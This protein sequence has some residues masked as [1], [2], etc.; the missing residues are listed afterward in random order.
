[1]AI[2]E[3]HTVK[4]ELTPEEILAITTTFT[5][6]RDTTIALGIEV[7]KELRHQLANIV[8]KIMLELLYDEGLQ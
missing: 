1:M 5:A 4:I 3:R 8:E 7:P 6:F 2:T